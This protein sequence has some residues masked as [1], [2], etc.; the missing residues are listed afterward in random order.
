MPLPSSVD[1]DPAPPTAI[2]ENVGPAGA[3]IDGVVYELL[4]TPHHV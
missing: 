1:A 4:A 3:G 2:G